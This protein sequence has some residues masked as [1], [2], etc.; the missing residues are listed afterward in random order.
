MFEDKS[1]ALHSRVSSFRPFG[2][3][4]SGFCDDSD[5]LR[6]GKTLSICRKD[7]ASFDKFRPGK[8]NKS[9]ILLKVYFYTGPFKVGLKFV[10]GI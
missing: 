8:I 7:A 10:K 1:K 9:N 6:L 2:E 4:G 5:E 3:N